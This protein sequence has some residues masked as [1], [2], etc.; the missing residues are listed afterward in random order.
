MS[1][2]PSCCCN[3]FPQPYQFP[4]NAWG[5]ATY[6]DPSWKINDGWR[7]IIFES[8]PIIGNLR[9]YNLYN[10]VAKVYAK[11]RNVQGRSGTFV[12]VEMGDQFVRL[13]KASR[14][15]GAV[16]ALFAIATMVSIA[17]FAPST[18]SFIAGGIGA[19]L[20]FSYGAYS[21]FRASMAIKY[22]KREAEEHL[23]SCTFTRF[24]LYKECGLPRP[25]RKDPKDNWGR[26]FLECLPLVGDIA[27]IILLR[28]LK[29]EMKQ[30]ET[31]SPDDS[32]VRDRATR[33]RQAQRI[34]GI[35]SV[36]AAIAAVVAVAL[37]ARTTTNLIACGVG[38]GLLTAYGIYNIYDSTKKIRHLQGFVPSL[39]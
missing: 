30:D 7:E 16:C 17:V 34:N 28:S 15:N 12:M 37:L 29:N 19:G 22:I 2:N 9:I 36:L 11:A 31:V 39:L 14:L 21:M 5:R 18:N 25:F 8:I 35:L 38:G 32:I 6:L 3:C 13:W 23:E 1:T 24:S 10:D 20:L 27:R 33:L 4:T 26:I